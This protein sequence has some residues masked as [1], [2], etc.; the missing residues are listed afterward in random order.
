MWSSELRLHLD[1]G[2]LEHLDVIAK[3]WRL[4]SLLD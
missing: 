2:L 3:E 4:N 1:H